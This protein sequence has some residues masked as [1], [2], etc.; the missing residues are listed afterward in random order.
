MNNLT[1]ILILSALAAPICRATETRSESIDV[2]KLANAIYLAEG[3][4]RTKYPYGILRKY[5]QTS[6]RQACI[7]TINHAKRDYAL[8]RSEKRDFITFLGLRYCPLQAKND[9]KGLNKNWV[10]NV[11]KLYYKRSQ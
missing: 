10:K 4:A 2:N 6:P 1:K 9:S 5:K 7:N 11:K 8:A 3:G